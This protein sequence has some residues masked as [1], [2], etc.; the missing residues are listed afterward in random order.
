MFE[1][2]LFKDNRWQFT[3]NARGKADTITLQLKDMLGL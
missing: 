2:S 1:Q 3:S